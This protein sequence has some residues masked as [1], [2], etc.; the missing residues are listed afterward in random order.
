MEYHQGTM[1]VEF[2]FASTQML[3]SPQ[4]HDRLRRFTS[5]RIRFP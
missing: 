3:Q 2:P 4:T 1:L 5:L